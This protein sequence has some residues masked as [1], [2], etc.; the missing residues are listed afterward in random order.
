MSDVEDGDSPLE[1]LQSHQRKE[2][3]DLKEKC[4][5]LK[6]AA[7]C[8]NKQKQKEANAEIEELEK[9]METRHAK[10][11]DDLS[12]CLAKTP[13]SSAAAVVEKETKEEPQAAEETTFYKAGN[14]SAKSKK[15][16]AK[17][18]EASQKMKSAILADQVA[19]LD[20]MKTIESS[21]LE[22]VLTD[23]GL[24]LVDIRPD[25][26]CLY[27]SVAHQM[28]R[29]TATPEIQ[30]KDVRRRAARFMLENRDDFVPFI[31]NEQGD[32]LDEFEY[33]NYCGNVESEAKNGGV[34][35]GEP[36]LIAISRSLERKIEV[37]QPEGRCITYGEEYPTRPLTIV[38]QR[39]AYSLGEH[40]N[41]TEPKK[42][43]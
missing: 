21:A 2:K 29:A 6:K 34:W 33:E 26:D 40:Y 13:L 38:Y 16:Q 32:P 19:A 4:L 8:G 43:V 39:H 37:I 41:S 23:R 20:S 11:I 15:K 1:V 42:I 18:A 28:N 27:N 12:Q 25:G 30:G 22:Q 3:K 14:V 9:A 35:G 5:A 7:K 17:K 36:E 31:T 10:E 24:Q